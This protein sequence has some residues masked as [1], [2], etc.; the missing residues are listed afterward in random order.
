MIK[1][2]VNKAINQSKKIYIFVRNSSDGGCIYS[3]KA[4]KQYM[5]VE[6]ID[7]ECIFYEEYE[8]SP[9]CNE[10]SCQNSISILMDDFNEEFLRDYLVQISNINDVYVFDFTG[11]FN[12]YNYVKDILNIPA[13]NIVRNMEGYSVCQIITN[14]LFKENVTKINSEVAN[15]LAKGILEETS[16][17]KFIK[18]G[19]F[20]NLA[21]LIEHGAVYEE[22]LKENTSKYY[23]GD[24]VGMAK[25]FLK[26]NIFKI[27]ETFGAFVIVN[28]LEMEALKRDY[29]IW[30]PQKQI[31]KMSSLRGCSFFC[32][33]AEDASGEICA[34]LR[35][36]KIYG[37]INVSHLARLYGGDG[38]YNAAHFTVNK[39]SIKNQSEF[40]AEIK[41]EVVKLYKINQVNI[42][43]NEIDLQLKSILE[44]TKRLRKNV[45]AN[46]LNKVEVLVSQGANYSY[47]FEL[48][49]PYER[50][51]VENE[52]ISRIPRNIFTKSSP[53][54]SISL[55]E[56]SIEM[57]SRK[58]NA[59]ED[60]IL[61]AIYRFA[62]INVKSA[63]ISLPN[64]KM[65]T[66]D[67]RGNVV[68]FGVVSSESNGEYRE[69]NMVL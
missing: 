28:E 58:Y 8:Y 44:N 27:G 50:F 19:I 45:T 1:E 5:L 39:D 55:S 21:K 30:F 42:K 65:S 48:F 3:A 37:N 49:K 63:K 54:V 33:I 17:L 47:L 57:L 36:S 4:I 60:D 41:Q 53:E 29:G 13:N 2:I 61:K 69:V 40:F 51:M 16:N 35:S 20:K 38:E 6:G 68:F 31:F 64:G 10:V 59:T 7:A 14:E 43:L 56:K 26:T 15:L 22:A 11:K 34:E 32:I 24:E 12:K 9:K 66:I 62:D 23:L 52:L 25:V 18:P 67:N 46:I